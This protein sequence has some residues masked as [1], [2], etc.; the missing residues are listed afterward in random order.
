M[1]MISYWKDVK[2]I[3]QDNGL[4]FII[5]TYN[6]KKQDGNKKALGV[7]WK[8]YPQSRG[9]LAPCVIPKETR[10][11]ILAGLL[12]QAINRKDEE[13]IGKISKAIQYFTE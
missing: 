7:H 13:S 4:V 2:Q 10:S 6:H 12:H 11:A 9:V 3:H 1:K 5:G 8:T